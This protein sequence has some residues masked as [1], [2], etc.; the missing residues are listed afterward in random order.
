METEHY[1]VYNVFP[2]NSAKIGICPE[3]DIWISF[4]RNIK[5][6]SFSELNEINSW[7]NFD[8]GISDNNWKSLKSDLMRTSTEDLGREFRPYEN[9]WEFITD[10]LDPQVNRF[11]VK[12]IKSYNVGESKDVEVWTDSDCILIDTNIIE[13]VY[14]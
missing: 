9:L 12:D 5:R 14:F 3:D 7:L 13:E 8:L 10:V 4:N 1:Y 6:Y 11:K 2:V